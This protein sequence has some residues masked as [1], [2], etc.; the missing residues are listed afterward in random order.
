MTNKPSII[1]LIIFELL[2]LSVTT[3][4]IY[5]F[6][7]S[8]EMFDEGVYKLYFIQLCMMIFHLVK[9]PFTI[10]MY[11]YKDNKWFQRILPF[12][13][14]SDSILYFTLISSNML[15]YEGIITNFID[16]NNNFST[17]SIVI[18]IL[19]HIVAT[20]LYLGLI[21]IFTSCFWLPCFIEYGKRHNNMND[22][23]IIKPETNLDKSK[24][25]KVIVQ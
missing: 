10:I 11:H 22:N 17:Y 13:S 4:G 21:F 18:I 8:E 20:P 6:Y 16:N 7:T 14:L 2:I 25:I 3:F 1:A 19:G 9:L 15:W 12:T 5:T 24:M 23:N